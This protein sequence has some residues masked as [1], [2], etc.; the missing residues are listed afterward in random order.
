VHSD[1]NSRLAGSLTD[2]DRPHRPNPAA[3][4]GARWRVWLLVF[5]VATGLGLFSSFLAYRFTLAVGRD[6][7]Y[8]RS[9]MLLNGAYWYIWA[10]FTPVIVWGARRFRFER[11]TW[12]RAL[13]AHGG[14]VTLFSLSHIVGVE[15]IRY[16]MFAA[17]LPPQFSFWKAVERSTLQNFDWEMM[18]YWAIVGVSQAVLYYSE[19]QERKLKQA[20]LETR[21]V[22][23]QLQTLQQQLHPHFLFNTLHAIS[24]LMHRDVDAA[25]RTLARLSDLL[26][27]SLERVGLQEVALEQELEFLRKYLQIEQTRFQDRLTVRFEV[28]AEALDGLVPNLFLQPLVENAIRHGIS[29]RSGPGWIEVSARRAADRLWIEVSDNGA[30]LSQDAF[31][32]LQSGIGLST[33]RVRLHHL[34]GPDH[35]FEFHRRTQGLTVRIVIPW[36]PDPRAAAGAA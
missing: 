25:D 36:R 30:G 23:A 5:G 15:A 17:D 27:L 19:A 12:G 7:S 4:T 18:T 33:T 20:Q 35:R 2:L 31:T 16:W 34:Y 32:A 26:R 1:L 24:T 9:L 10:L 14:G 6:G 8:W 22:E 28:D 13:A 3:W 11:Q 29:P 21:L